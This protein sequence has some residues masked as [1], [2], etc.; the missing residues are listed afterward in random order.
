MT[1][2][3]NKSSKKTLTINATFIIIELKV[4][5]KGADRMIMDMIKVSKNGQL[6][7]DFEALETLTSKEFVD[8]V[9]EDIREAVIKKIDIKQV[10]TSFQEIKFLIEV[11]HQLQDETSFKAE[12]IM[13]YN[14]NPIKNRFKLMLNYNFDLLK[15]YLEWG[16]EK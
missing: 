10:S 12:R 13:V 11:E 1:I 2:T 16:E 8:Q 15:K 14:Y 7:F 4:A 3:R 6:E 5:L 9:K